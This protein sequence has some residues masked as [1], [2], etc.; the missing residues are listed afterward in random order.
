MTLT[1]YGLSLVQTRGLSV[2]LLKTLRFSFVELERK[3]AAYQHRHG[4]SHPTLN[5]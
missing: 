1:S 4:F 2:L 5:S 3:G